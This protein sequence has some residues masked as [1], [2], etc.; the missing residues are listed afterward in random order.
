MD[1]IIT[2]IIC[3]VSVVKLNILFAMI[4]LQNF[5]S[6]FFAIFYKKN[7]LIKCNS[8]NAVIKFCI[9]IFPFNLP[10]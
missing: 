4:G 2:N 5:V 1:K 8:F 7:N 9:C 6:I 3:K 10:S